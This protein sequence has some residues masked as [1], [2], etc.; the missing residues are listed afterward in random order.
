MRKV[1]KLLA[2]ILLFSIAVGARSEVIRESQETISAESCD[3]ATYSITSDSNMC[4]MAD[5]VLLLNGKKITM[6]K[7]GSKLISR[8]SS[9]FVSEGDKTAAYF[10]APGL[11]LRI[12]YT[13]LPGC[14]HRNDQ[15]TFYTYKAQ[16]KLS[17]TGKRTI[18][19]EGK[20]EVGS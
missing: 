17:R 1:L 15:C 4:L 10:V 14:D 8:K 18:T 16:F 11:K 5:D 13:I 3:T 2:A 7:I 6:K 20:G 9:K 19:Y 12:I